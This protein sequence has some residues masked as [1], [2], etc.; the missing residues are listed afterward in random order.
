MARDDADADAPREPTARRQAGRYL[1][2]L[3]LAGCSTPPVEPTPSPTPTPPVVA[4]APAPPPPVPEETWKPAPEWAAFTALAVEDSAAGCVLGLVR[5]APGGV[6]PLRTVALLPDACGDVDVT[7]SNDATRLALV[8]GPEHRSAL[9]EAGVTR[10]LPPLPKRAATVRFGEAGVLAFG[11]HDDVVVEVE[12]SEQEP[13][14]YVAVINGKK[15][16]G[17]IT[18]DAGGA[19]PCGEWRL[20][21]GAWVHEADGLA[22]F[23]ADQGDQCP[24]IHAGGA[25]AGTPVTLD[26]PYR[27]AGFPVGRAPFFKGTLHGSRATYTVESEWGGGGQEPAPSGELTVIVESGGARTTAE[28]TASIPMTGNALVA[29]DAPLVCST[30]LGGAVL[31]LAGATAEEAVREIWTGKHCLRRWPDALPMP[32][33][34]AP[35]EVPA[36]VPTPA[37]PEEAATPTP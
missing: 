28:V 25:L 14:G 16:Y 35:A 18:G 19:T 30:Q 4:P 9:V 24:F 29:F 33:A 12:H 21:E 6:E 7:V 1:T 15:Y 22:G 26:F 2:A 11:I 36:P 31:A 5:V 8:Y 34:A 13:D 27:S 20:A 17:T 23:D 32:P 37:P 3:L 10:L